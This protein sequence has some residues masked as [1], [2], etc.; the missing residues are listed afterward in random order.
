MVS[1][2]ATVGCRPTDI[3]TRSGRT[4]GREPA[5]GR[6]GVPP[7][8]RAQEDLLLRRYAD[9]PDGALRE[10]LV[11][12]FMPLVWSL[13]RRYRGGSE[14]LDDLVQVGSLGLVKAIDGFD[15]ERGR[16][17]AAYAVPTIQGELRRHFRDHVWQVHLPRYLQERTLDVEEATTRLTAQLGRVPSVAQI[18]ERLEIEQEEVLEAMLADDA[19]RTLSLD[20]PAYR[21]EED[22]VP[23]VETVGCEEPR[24][25]TVEASLSAK[26]AG[27]DERELRV[28]RLRFVDD[29]SQSEIGER[30]GVSQMH[31]S[32]ILRAALRQLL[33]A[34]QG[35]N[36]CGPVR[37]APEARL[38]A[39]TQRRL[40]AH[41][42]PT[43]KEDTMC[44]PHGRQK[45]SAP[46]VC[47]ADG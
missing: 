8:Q 47:R 42:P 46:D 12:R 45:T 19:R 27:L 24:F 25:D 40:G 26:T 9:C 22:A 16:T 31:V 20:A 36:G 4:N 11:A 18:A 43:P 1:S 10:E 41:P 29:L 28:L 35:V 17:F 38:S 44:M 13:A 37:P 2:S 34:V 3:T 23:A 33:G 21:D 6:R 5:H 14:P 15:P 39:W 7:Q 32:R 30:I